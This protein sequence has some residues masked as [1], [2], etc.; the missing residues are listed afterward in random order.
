MELNRIEK[1]VYYDLNDQK[2]IDFFLDNIVFRFNDSVLK[3]CTYIS[4]SSRDAMTNVLSC[5]DSIARLTMIF[6]SQLNHGFTIELCFDNVVRFNLVPTQIEFD[7]IWG[8]SDIK[9]YSGYIEFKA[10]RDSYID[11]DLNNMTWVKAKSLRIMIL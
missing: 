7:S 1:N 4:G 8:D 5:V 6:E 10:Y 2:S 11:I 3:E 9:I